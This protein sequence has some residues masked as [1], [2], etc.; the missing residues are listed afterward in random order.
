MTP[1]LFA[2][3]RNAELSRGRPVCVPPMDYEAKGAV[4]WERK[5]MYTRSEMRMAGCYRDWC[6]MVYGGRYWRFICA[7]DYLNGRR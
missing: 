4:E 1:E 2:E 3:Y 5:T 7:A 6:N